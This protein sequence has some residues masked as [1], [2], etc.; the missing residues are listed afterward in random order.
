LRRTFRFATFPDVLV[1]NAARFRLNN[2]VEQKLDV[3]I[4]LPTTLSLDQY[5]AT[6]KLE[7]EEELPEDKAGASL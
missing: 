2:W 1:V 6:G 5:L 3:P 4:S 7:G